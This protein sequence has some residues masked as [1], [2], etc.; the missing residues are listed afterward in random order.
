MAT[1]IFPTVLL[2][3]STIIGLKT[4]SPFLQKLLLFKRTFLRSTVRKITL[5]A[6]Q[7]IYEGG[8]WG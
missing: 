4:V 3:L 6:Q 5:G 7:C 1:I 2:H 8:I